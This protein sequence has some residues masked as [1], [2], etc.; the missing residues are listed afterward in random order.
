MAMRARSWLSGVSL[1]RTLVSRLRLTVR[2]LREPRVSVLSKT[3]PVLATLYVLSPFD[4]VPD[5]IPFFGQLDDLGV[6]LIALE[7]FTKVCPPG[8]VDFH[9]TA[10][11]QGPPASEPSPGTSFADPGAQTEGI[12]L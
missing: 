11:A 6:M 2:L 5:F 7:M 10:I 3:W 12:Q 9:R 4:V 1:L 8:A